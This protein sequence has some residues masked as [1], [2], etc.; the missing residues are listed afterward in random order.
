MST[1]PKTEVAIIGSGNITVR[2]N[3]PSTPCASQSSSASPHGVAPPRPRPQAVTRL[4]PAGLARV[5][6]MVPSSG[7]APALVSGKDGMRKTGGTGA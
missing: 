4:C 6:L 7:C 1:S 2:T 5:M 3:N